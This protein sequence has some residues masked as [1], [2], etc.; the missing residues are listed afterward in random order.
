M[1]PTFYYSDH[2]GYT[3]WHSTLFPANGWY[4]RNAHTTSPTGYSTKKDA[5]SAAKKHYRISRWKAAFGCGKR[6]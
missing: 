2:T 4:W 6:G 3:V 1:F 5:M